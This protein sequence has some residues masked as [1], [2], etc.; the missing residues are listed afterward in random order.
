MA[1]ES[2]L[3]S[4]LCAA[5]GDD[6]RCVGAIGRIAEGTAEADATSS[7]ARPVQAAVPHG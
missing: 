6:G 5:T 4:A 3:G 2:A 7:A 1:A